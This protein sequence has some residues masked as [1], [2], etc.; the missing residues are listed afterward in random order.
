V[1]DILILLFNHFSPI[2]GICLSCED[3]A[4]QSCAMVDRWRIFASCIFSRPPAAHFR[5]AF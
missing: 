3:I 1:E 2:V 4:N 5:P